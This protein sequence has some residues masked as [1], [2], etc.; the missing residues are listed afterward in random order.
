VL[1]PGQRSLGLFCCAASGYQAF[2]QIMPSTAA[3]SLLFCCIAARHGPGFTNSSR[4]Q[5][6]L[7]IS[8]FRHT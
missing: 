5:T 4:T 6:S 3:A 1:P 8:D 2:G 7:P